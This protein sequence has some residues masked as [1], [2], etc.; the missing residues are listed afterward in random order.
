MPKTTQAAPELELST[1]I[2]QLPGVGPARADVLHEAGMPTVYDVLAYLPFRFEDRR[3]F[4]TIAALST[5]EPCVVLARV[6]SARLIRTRRRDFTMVEAFV[7][8][9]T[10]RIKIF[11]F[12]RPY[13]ARSLKEGR[14]IVLYGQSTLKAKGPLL[15]N[16]EYELLDDDD[17]AEGSIHFGRVVPIYRR[18][19][20]LSPRAIRKLIAATLDRLAVPTVERERVAGAFRSL[21]F[22][23]EIDEVE[24]A[25]RFLGHREVLQFQVG[26]AVRHRLRPRR[27]A[28]LEATVPQLVH[29]SR[30]RAPFTLT[31]AQEAALTDIFGDLRR[32]RPMARLLHGEVGSGK[33]AVA[34]L[35]SMAV[36]G[37]GEQVALVAPTE[38]LAHQ[39]F[40]EAR[41][42]LTD[43]RVGLLTSSTPAPVRRRLLGELSSG[44]TG[45]IVGTHALFQ[46]KVGF[47][48]LG[49]VIVDEQH[50]FGVFQRAALLRKAS[51]QRPADLLVMSA[52]P[53]PRTLTLTLYGD[54]EV[55]RMAERP[56]GRREVATR[57]LRFPDR[58]VAYEALR[59][60]VE[61]REQGFV[62]VP[63]IRD[64]TRKPGSKSN[65][66]R[67]VEAL[68][69]KHPEWRIGV[70]H[71]KLSGEDKAAVAEDLRRRRI[72]VVVA[73]TVVEVGVDVPGASVMVVLAAESFGL[74]QLHQLRGRAGRG[75]VPGS[76]FLVGSEGCPAESWERIQVMERLTDGFSVAEADWEQRGPGDMGGSR[77]WG[78]GTFRIADQALVDELVVE[79]REEGREIARSMRLDAARA[80]LDSWRK[81]FGSAGV[82]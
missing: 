77:Q 3:R 7:E 50:R 79:A 59:A 19:R 57:V 21:H 32:A 60:A 75:D 53:I 11:W 17:R 78:G 25:R 20:T 67:V 18:L 43:E 23:G 73:T 24:P 76:A 48:N 1:S 8:D 34:L 26:L 29:A 10:G 6:V 68:R 80:L 31:P 15:E 51:L 45:L 64:S 40:A 49:L 66:T 30:D 33:T 63:R 13:L 61:R 41:R 35:A 70:L 55:T 39:L 72:D 14:A 38:V 46:E 56:E 71:G 44:R 28:P 65:L 81:Q 47:A 12:N 62:V 2:E 16:P 54:L 42:L 82:G 27:K 22:P 69:Q 52:T 4:A 5:D 74:S 58:G 9:D 36:I 37:A